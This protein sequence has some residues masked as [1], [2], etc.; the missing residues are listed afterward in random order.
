MFERSSIAAATI[1]AA[2]GFTI[3]GAAAFDEAKY[4]DWS[5]LWVRPKG[6][7]TQWD[8]TKPRAPPRSRR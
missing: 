3:A 1:A 6:Q 8:P 7:L 4:P 2:L 5:G